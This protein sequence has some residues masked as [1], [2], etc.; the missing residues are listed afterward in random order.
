MW[1]LSIQQVGGVVGMVLTCPCLL[2]GIN[3]DPAGTGHQ[4]SGKLH[5]EEETELS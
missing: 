2:Q 5:L 4:Q 1:G 3:A